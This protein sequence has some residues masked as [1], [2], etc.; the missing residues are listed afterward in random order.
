M[1][2]RFLDW[3]FDEA[4]PSAQAGLLI[5]FSVLL[6]GICLIVF[7]LPIFF[8]TLWLHPSDMALAGAIGLW[9]LVLLWVGYYFIFKGL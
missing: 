5:L 6:V 4:P 2:E 9:S 7:C 8:L 3:C 1:L